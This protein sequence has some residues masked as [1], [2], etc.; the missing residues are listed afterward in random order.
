[1]EFDYEGM[2]IE[3]GIEQAERFDYEGLIVSIWVPV[4]YVYEE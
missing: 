1:M 4:I 3:V 2:V